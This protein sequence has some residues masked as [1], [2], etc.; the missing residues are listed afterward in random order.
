MI[1]NMGETAHRA[2]VTCRGNRGND[3]ARG[4]SQTRYQGQRIGAARRKRTSPHATAALS[5]RVDT[6]PASFANRRSVRRNTTPNASRN[7]TRTTEAI[8]LAA[9]EPRIPLTAAAIRI[10]TK[11]D[12]A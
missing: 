3:H 8:A 10:W 6:L 7:P 12:A 11:V 1:K 2:T 4:S 5:S 9:P